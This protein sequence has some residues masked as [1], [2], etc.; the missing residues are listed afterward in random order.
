[1]S[2]L[3]RDLQAKDDVDETLQGI[4]DAAVHT[5]PGAGYAGLSVVRGRD[6]MSTPIASADL[7]HE[8]DRAQIDFA[9]GPCMDAL[10]DKHTVSLPDMGA[11]QRWPLFAARAVEL[12]IGSMLSFQL[13]VTGN[14]LGALN[15]YAHEIGAFTPESER[16][17]LLFAAHAAVAMADAQHAAHLALALDT[18][19][20]IGQA[21]GILMERYKLSPDQAF[22][23]LVRASQH[24][25]TKLAQIA[26]N[27][28]RTGHLPG[29]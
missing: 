11:E 12:G 22:A 13:Y 27:L 7:V 28:A 20:L 3:A 18:R 9:Q 1:M 16:V 14:D 8:V 10:Y 2:D 24:T 19:D 29:P 17:G 21:K 5:V 23:L 6:T 15:L 4:V 26:D 25:N